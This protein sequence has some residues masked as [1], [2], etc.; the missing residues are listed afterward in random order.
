MQKLLPD[1]IPCTFI[2]ISLFLALFCSATITLLAQYSEPEQ[3][4]IGAI[5]VCQDSY[6]QNNSYTGPGSFVDVVPYETCLLT[7][8][9]NSVWYIF[10]VQIGGSFGFTIITI[11]DYFFL[12]GEFIPVGSLAVQKTALSHSIYSVDYPITGLTYTITNPET[13]ISIS[14][15]SLLF[16]R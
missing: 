2:K 3:N 5:P 16:L 14:I 8:E 12:L 4:C 6:T 13:F 1:F 15:T 9:T 7:G 10:T 11:Y